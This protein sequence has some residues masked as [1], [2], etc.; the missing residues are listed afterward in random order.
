VSTPEIGHMTGCAVIDPDSQK[1]GTVKDVV[2]DDRTMEMR[3]AVIEY[4][5]THHR[6]LVPASTLYKSEDGN[7]VTMLHK[8]FIKNAPRIHGDVPITDEAEQYYGVDS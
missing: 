3:W 1:V 4:G 2:F 7:V 8:D 6:T 5:L